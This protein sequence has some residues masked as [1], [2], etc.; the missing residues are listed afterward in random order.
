MAETESSDTDSNSG[1]D[2]ESET[3]ERL[4]TVFPQVDL[5]PKE[6]IDDANQVEQLQEPLVQERE[7][8][9][10]TETDE[11]TAE[12]VVMGGPLSLSDPEDDESSGEDSLVEGRDGAASSNEDEPDTPDDE[13][14]L[15]VAVQESP[16]PRPRSPPIP[17]PRPRR[18]RR[19]PAWQ[20]SQDYIL[21]QLQESE[22][23]APGK[24]NTTPDWAERATFL[25][26]LA[27]NNTF[28]G[29]PEHVSRS[30]IQIVMKG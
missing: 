21:Y 4:F 16:E 24:P 22:L 19:V 14:E 29:L 18:E 2:T 13:D 8:E 10:D 23:P 15:P 17:A 11:G 3:S 25:A 5:Q 26:S 12:P 1:S 6:M 9:Q 27:N 20:A 7:Q 30:I 28:T